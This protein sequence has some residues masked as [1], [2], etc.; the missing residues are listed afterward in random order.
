MGSQSDEKLAQ[1]TATG[2]AKAVLCHNSGAG[3][4]L[5]ETFARAATE[6][7]FEPIWYAG[8]GR[9]VT[10]SN[11]NNELRDDFYQSAA[12]VVYLDRPRSGDFNDHWALQELPPVGSDVLILLAPDF[13]LDLLRT[14]TKNDVTVVATEEEFAEAVRAY[15]SKT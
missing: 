15:L 12:R 2:H 9:R 8:A 13:P 11:L 7:G 6:C 5:Q 3:I 14:W 10:R 4:S 1:Q